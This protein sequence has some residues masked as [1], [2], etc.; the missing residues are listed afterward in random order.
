MYIPSSIKHDR[1]RMYNT[2]MRHIQCV[3]IA[4]GIQHAM[5]MHHIVICETSGSTKFFHINSLMTYS[6]KVIEHEMCVLVFSTT[7]VSNISH[8]KK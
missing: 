1:Q 8:S 5:C 2:T 7:F 6:K 4:L 3:F